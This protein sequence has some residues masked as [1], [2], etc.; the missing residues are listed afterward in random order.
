MCGL[1]GQI[2]AW[3]NGFDLPALEQFGHMMFL[4]QLRGSDSTGVVGVGKD[5]D[6]WWIRAVGGWD[7]LRFHD[8]PGW[9][10]FE[11]PLF[12]KGKI[13]FGHGRQATRGDITVA[14]AHPFVQPK[15]SGKKAHQIILV[16]NG[17]L[18]S[19][20][21]LKDMDKYDVDS[22]W[23]TYQIAQLGAKEALAKINGA[24]ATMWYDSEECTFNVYRND[25]RPLFAMKTK[26]GD[27]FINSE[28]ASLMW[29][30]LKHKI[31][32]DDQLLQFD[33]GMLYTFKVPN[34]DDMTKT[35]VASTSWYSG[36]ENTNDYRYIQPPP[37]RRGPYGDVAMW[38]DRTMLKDMH[39]LCN[40][41]YA[42]VTFTD[43][44]RHTYN[45]DGTIV[46]DKTSPYELHLIQLQA[47]YGEPSRITKDYEMQGTKWTVEVERINGQFEPYV[48]AKIRATPLVLVKGFPEEP[49]A[50]EEELKNNGNKEHSTPPN[51][52]VEVNYKAGKEVKFTTPVY[53]G[54][55]EV[56]THKA[57]CHP[58]HFSYFSSYEN[59]VDGRI[60]VGDRV[61]IEVTEVESQGKNR[62]TRA[63]GVRL[64]DRMDAV[65]DCVFYSAK[66]SPEQVNRMKF[67]EGV[68]SFMQVAS[69]EQHDKTRSF[70]E[71]RL[72]DVIPCVTLF[73][74]EVSNT[75]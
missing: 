54:V 67:F 27:W 68:V 28:I 52:C 3:K 56:I 32:T 48:P 62:L 7:N 70:I 61:K 53:R 29:L 36:W 6:H 60:R 58:Q 34:T 37:G 18:Q 17:T 5:Q 66:W 31:V 55:G 47:V 13:A 16:H 49:D 57:I 10:G 1:V 35:K 4:N 12:Q 75:H 73:A 22:E 44:G 65:I 8:V 69:K 50:L 21:T 51:R 71:V 14:N 11:D 39:A 74:D 33:S 23:M 26:M 42:K 20:Q 2:Y 64:A 63:L 72:N 25:E 59:N 45:K 15:P 19:H 41:T 9:K 24:I 43:K 40:G 30:K 38:G 46:H